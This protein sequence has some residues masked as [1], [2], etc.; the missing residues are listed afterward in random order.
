[1]VDLKACATTP[2]KQ[3]QVFKDDRM[4]GKCECHLTCQECPCL[5]A[6]PSWGQSLGRNYSSL[7]SSYSTSCFPRLRALG[8]LHR[9]FHS[10][11]LLHLGSP[12]FPESHTDKE[13]AS[14]GHLLPPRGHTCCGFTGT[15]VSFSISH[16]L[17]PRPTIPKN[18]IALVDR[19]L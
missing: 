10:L 11:A 16:V 14:R 12:G 2:T 4:F 1:M 13:A 6:S 3:P 9:G 18:S 5:E 17:K 15:W 8:S 19:G 7:K